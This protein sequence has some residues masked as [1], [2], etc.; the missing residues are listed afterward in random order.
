M[1]LNYDRGELVDIEALDE[2]LTSGKIRHAAIDA[3]IF[4]QRW[5]G[6]T[7]TARS[8]SAVGGPSTPEKLALLPHAAADTDHPT[9]VG[10]WRSLRS[11]KS[12]MQFGIGP[13]PT[14]RAAFQ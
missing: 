5:T 1:L 10:G 4:R 11:I 8:L 13:L 6:P 7:G 3:D 14:S 9:R 2:A 12:S